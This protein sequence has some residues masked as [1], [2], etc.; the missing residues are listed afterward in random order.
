MT[1]RSD[2]SPPRRK[3]RSYVLREG[4]ITTAQ[5]RAFE[6]HWPRF[7]IDYDAG[8]PHDLDAW[9]GRT[10]PHVLEIGFGNGEAL[11]WASEHDPDRDYLGIEVHRPGVGRL[12]NALAAR[13]ARNVRLWNH[14]AVEVLEHAIPAHSLDEVR[15]W[16]PDPWHKKRHHKRRL[17]QPAFAQLLATRVKP[18]GL[19]HLA[20]DWAEYAAQMREVLDASPAWRNRNGN[21]GH[22]QRPPWRIATRFEQR[23]RK[24]G[25]GVW[26]LLYGRV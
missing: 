11:A 2:E 3:I 6:L 9:F 21:D 19:L 5:Q 8:E 1:S 18:G 24:L 13:D 16:F 17:I 10:A 15:I 23:G 20:T 4:R 14:D 26:D 12:M 7:G 25:H 22:A